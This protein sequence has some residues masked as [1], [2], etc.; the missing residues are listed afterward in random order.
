MKRSGSILMAVIA[1]AVVT[2]FGAMAPAHADSNVDEWVHFYN[3]G[4]YPAY[5]D[6]YAYNAQGTLL[7]HDWSGTQWHGGGKWFNVPAGTATVRWEARMDPFGNTIH[8][9]TMINGWYNFNE[10]C[11][12]GKHATI[13]VGGTPNST[14]HYDM[15]CSNW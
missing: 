12:G 4:W 5:V 15:H 13:Y 1:M 14:N 3:D 11:Q 8:E 9:Q 10:Y 6:L 7:Y 2:T